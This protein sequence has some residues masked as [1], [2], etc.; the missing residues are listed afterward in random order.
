MK[1]LIIV[2]AAILALLALLLWAYFQAPNSQPGQAQLQ[3]GRDHH[4]EGTK[5]VYN[6]NPPTSGDHYPSWITKGVY[7]T[8]REDGY[9]V[10]SL[11]HGYVIIWYDC[12]VQP[13]GWNLVKQ[14]FAQEVS[15]PPR[16]MSAGFEGT[17]SATLA[18]MPEA[19][20]SPQCDNLRKDITDFYNSIDHHKI[21]AVPRAHMGKRIVVTSWGRSLDLSKVD[22][23]EIENFIDVY[24]D[25]GPEQTDEP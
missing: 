10:H 19:F 17:P 13:T 23:M 8:P 4:P 16:S 6:F 1:K 5:Y 11:E 20:R 7:D 25:H 3:P 21:I 12:E 24:R 14:A 15:S 22:R 9:L 2:T 18:E